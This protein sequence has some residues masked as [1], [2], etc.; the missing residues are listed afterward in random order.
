MGT[1]CSKSNLNQS[2]PP[3]S[4]SSSSS[5]T[6]RPNRSQSESSSHHGVSANRSAFVR[7]RNKKWQQDYT[8]T[9]T[10]GQGITG[11]VHLVQKNGTTDYFAK[12]S[13]NI[14]DQ[15]PAQM[16]ELR[17]E[18]DLLRELD[19]PN[20][21]HL[22]ECYEHDGQIHLI[23]ENC[24]G[25]ELYAMF[26]HGTEEY[27]AFTEDEISK[28]C[29]GALS[30]LAYCHSKGIVHRDL[31]PQNIVF[32]TAGNLNDIKIIDFGMSK[33]GMKRTRFGRRAVQTA[34]GTPLYVAPE[35]ICGARYDEKIDIWAIGVLAYHMA[36]GRHPFQ[37][38]SQE[39]TLDNIERHTAIRF[40]GKAW[41]DKSPILQSFID[42]LLK[43]KISKRPSA[44]E[45]LRHPFLAGETPTYDTPARQKRKESA[46]QTM[47][48]MQAFSKYPDIKR[49]ALMAIAHKL[50]SKEI[51][52][53]RES[54]QKLDTSN[55]G[56]IDR[57]EFNQ[58]AKE[59]G[60]LH[61]SGSI[62]EGELNAIFDAADID[63]TGQI[64][65]GEFL[66]A[67]LD[68]SVFLR[69][70]RLRDAFNLLDDDSSGT[71][72]CNN[73]M[74]LLGKEFTNPTEI[75]DMIV[76]GDSKKNGVIDFEEFLLMMRMGNVDADAEEQ[77]KSKGVVQ[78]GEVALLEQ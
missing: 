44:S 35:I 74:N 77:S 39:E 2:P 50:H 28:I 3:P 70:D 32:P 15:D 75:N 46:E 8:I 69:E 36:A 33:R 30:A 56:T 65:Y 55:S 72:T 49:T 73:L 11:S 45:A 58:L 68:T 60:A 41:R 23:M 13:I 78:T 25:G 6:E 29:H 40:S 76:A 5:S 63:G 62:S 67:T 34:C 24:A 21:V 71:I 64:A 53:L 22:Y 52:S 4:S 66:A 20:I 26:R 42:L 14:E 9:E 61:A 18:I 17:N 59:T 51:G 1:L 47:E 37:G 43:P 48:R 38:M 57:S 12:K 27:H 10:L 54:F 19:H 7:T 31:K 16:K